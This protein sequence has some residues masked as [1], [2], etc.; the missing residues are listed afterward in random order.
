MGTHPFVVRAFDEWL[1]DTRNAFNVHLLDLFYW[2]QRMGNWQA[3][4]QL[5]WD[6]VQEV[7]TPLNC[8]SLL[9]TMLS[10]DEKYR[11]PPEF[12]LHRQLILSLWPDVLSEPINPHR[13][14]RKGIRGGAK[15]LL[16]RTGLGGLV[17]TARKLMKNL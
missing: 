15:K 11:R 4:S 2:E 3:M 7:F 8:R 9:A 12:R 13:N 1:S 14:C 10:V 16:A 6:I 17:Q 5:E